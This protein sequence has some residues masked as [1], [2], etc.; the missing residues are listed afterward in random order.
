[1]EKLCKFN[2]S[3]VKLNFQWNFFKF[4]YL[5]KLTR[6]KQI[7]TGQDQNNNMIFINQSNLSYLNFLV[8]KP[9][10]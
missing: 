4:Q 6:Q 3:T 2:Q 9:D 1:M 10:K 5:K 7:R 8:K